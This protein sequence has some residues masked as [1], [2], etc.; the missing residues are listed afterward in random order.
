ME[1]LEIKITDPVGLHARPASLVVK[2]AMKYKS[3]INVYFKDKKA[4]LKSVLHVMSLGA[5]CN[6]ELIITAEG[7]DEK[8][9]IAGIK[10]SF[11]KNNLS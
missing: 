8:E 7:E 5:P 1:K 11:V 9:A 4:N 10:D 6:S 3:E 2:E